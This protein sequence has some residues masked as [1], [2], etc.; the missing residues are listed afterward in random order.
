MVTSGRHVSKNRKLRD[1]ISTASLKQSEPEV[2]WDT[3]LS[4]STPRRGELALC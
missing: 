3:K 1:P 2:N 4:R